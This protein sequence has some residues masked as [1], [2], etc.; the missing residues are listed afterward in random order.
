M[1]EVNI[2]EVKK[3]LNT[4]IAGYEKPMRGKFAALMPFKTEIFKL[5]AKGAT[6]IEIRD[7]MDE[8]KVTV[9]KD[10]M[11]RFLHDMKP[12]KRNISADQPGA[13]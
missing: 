4:I 13:K 7:I 10:T 9:S 12:Q 11:Q 1:S 8:A 5:K 6:A 3:K 2:D